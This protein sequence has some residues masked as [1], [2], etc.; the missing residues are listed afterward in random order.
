MSQQL[1]FQISLEMKPEFMG[2]IQKPRSSL[3]SS[4]YPNTARQVF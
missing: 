1:F 4:Q 2:T 3:A